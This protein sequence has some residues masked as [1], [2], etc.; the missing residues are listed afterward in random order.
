MKLYTAWLYG[1]LIGVYSSRDKAKKA[2]ND[3]CDA[4]DI[5]KDDR[6]DEI[7]STILDQEF[8]Y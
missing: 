4:E 2:Y 8:E 1:N 7:N 3:M 6:D 5:D